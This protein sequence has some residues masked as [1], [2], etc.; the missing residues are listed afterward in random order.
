V[1]TVSRRFVRGA[2]A[3]AVGLSKHATTVHALG[4]GESAGCLDDAP[5]NVL[6]PP[7]L[8]KV[9]WTPVNGQ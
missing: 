5:A 3:A 8:T 9:H 2:S 1:V 7:P 6:P 4:G